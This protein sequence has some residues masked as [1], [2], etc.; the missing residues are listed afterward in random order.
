MEIGSR[1]WN[2]FTIFRHL[3]V[4]QITQNIN[5]EPL[6]CFIKVTE[7]SVPI[8]VKICFAGSM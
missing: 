6:M 7:G 5:V 1:L 4:N 2:Y 3:E 8:R